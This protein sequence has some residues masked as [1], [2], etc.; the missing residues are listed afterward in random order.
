MK[1]IGLLLILILI[2]FSLVGCESDGLLKGKHYVE[3]TVKDY[4]KIKLELDADVAPITVTNFIKLVKSNFYDGTTF[5]RIINGFMIQGGAPK[6]NNYPETI[7][8]EFS[9]NGYENNILHERGVISMA[10]SNQMNSASSQF[11]IVHQDSPHL[12]GNYAAFGRVISGMVVVDKIAQV[13]IIPNTDGI[14]ADE[15]QPIIESIR[16]VEK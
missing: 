14:V 4:G 16:V 7:V 2:S 15:N 11:F 1:K 10:R 5:H 13:P 12:N 6:D 8:G 3:I 9:K